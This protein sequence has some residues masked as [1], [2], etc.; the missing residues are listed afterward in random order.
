M[1]IPG[2]GGLRRR[3]VGIRRLSSVSE[4]VSGVTG[5]W[6]NQ[7]T[8]TCDLSPIRGDSANCSSHCKERNG[9][10]RDRV[11]SGMGPANDNSLKL[12]LR[13]ELSNWNINGIG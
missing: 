6:M 7:G 5:Q 13:A 8:V 12:S 2:D 4:N 9:D 1:L 11:G 10:S 3:I